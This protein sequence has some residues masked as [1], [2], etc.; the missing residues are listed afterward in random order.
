MNPIEPALGCPTPLNG[1]E[2]VLA[3][4]PVCPGVAIGCTG[5]RHRSVH[6]ATL[7]GAQ[8][9]KL[10]GVSG[11]PSDWSVLVSH[12]DLTQIAPERPLASNASPPS[13]RAAHDLRSVPYLS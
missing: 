3:G 2:A 6:V 4:L 7:L 11:E 1:L 13:Q 10:G 5:G 9:A 8:L 12:R